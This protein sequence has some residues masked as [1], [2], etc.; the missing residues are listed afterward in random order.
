MEHMIA[1]HSTPAQ[2][3]TN[4]RL[5]IQ[6][7]RQVL[8]TADDGETQQA[9]FRAIAELEARIVDVYAALECEMTA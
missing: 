7:W 9:A 6:A 3:L 4:V 8:A 2:Q 1:Q 5:K